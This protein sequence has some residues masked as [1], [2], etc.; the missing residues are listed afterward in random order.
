MKT[1]KFLG[2]LTISPQKN[3]PD[4]VMDEVSKVPE[5]TQRINVLKEMIRK[6]REW[7]MLIKESQNHLEW[8]HEEEY[9]KRSKQDMRITLGEEVL[10]RKE[11]IENIY[12]EEDKKKEGLKRHFDKFQENFQSKKAEICLS[13]K[14]IQFENKNE[15]YFPES[16]LYKKFNEKNFKLNNVETKNL[17]FQKSDQ[18]EN[19]KDDFEKSN[20]FCNEFIHENIFENPLYDNNNKDTIFDK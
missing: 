5:W 8:S 4:P 9:E 19:L 6:E 18:K 7:N 2:T 16:S 1:H 17:F 15:E 13:V 11:E 12:K 14:R 10:K 20:P 3:T